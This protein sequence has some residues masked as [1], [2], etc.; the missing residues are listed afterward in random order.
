MQ[1]GPKSLVALDKQKFIKKN[2]NRPNGRFIYICYVKNFT[3]VLFLPLSVSTF[4]NTY[5]PKIQPFID[6]RKIVKTPHAL[7]V[8]PEQQPVPQDTLLKPVLHVIHNS[9]DY[10]TSD[11]GTLKDL[12]MQ[13]YCSE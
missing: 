10:Y 6:S 8:L 4:F 1:N 7:P 2:D 12:S 9:K 11:T 5:A 13:N 3:Y